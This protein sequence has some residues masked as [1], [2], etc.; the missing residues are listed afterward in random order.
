MYMILCGNWKL[1]WSRFKG[2]SLQVLGSFVNGQDKQWAVV[3][4]TGEFANASGVVNIKV[5]QFLPETTGV[6]R[7]LNIHASCPCV[8]NPVSLPL[9]C[10]H[11]NLSISYI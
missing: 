6:I 4:G 2:S 5:I 3:G 8:P 1:G 9:N 10:S 11:H 7:E